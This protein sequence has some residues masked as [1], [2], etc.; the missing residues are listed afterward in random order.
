[1]SRSS[2]KLNRPLRSGTV[3][4]LAAFLMTVLVG[5][6]AFAID[7]GMIGLVREQ[8][9]IAADAGAMAGAN[10]LS[11]GTTTAQ[12][13]AQTFAQAN[14]V[15]G[16]NVS[17]VPSQDIQFGTWNK[18]AYTFTPLT[19]AAISGANAVKVTCTV[20]QARG[21]S[22]TL[23]FGPVLG[24][25][26]ADISMSAIATSSP[27]TCGAF[28]GINSVTISGGSYTDSYD[29]SAGAY[30]SGSAGKL[31]TVCS[32]GKISL[33]GGSTVVNGDAHPGPGSTVSASGGSSVTGSTTPLTSALN[34][35]AVNSGSAS[36]SNDNS[37]IPTSAL[38]KT[39]LDTSRN[40][41]LSGG[42]S[43]TLSP[44]T[45]YFNKFTLSGGSSVTITGK[46]II[47]CAGD[48]NISGGSLLNTTALPVN[49]QLYGMGSKVVLSG[50]SQWCGV[51][52]A[53]GCDVTRSGGSSDFFGMCVGKTLTLSGGGGLHYDTSLGALTGASNG[54]QLVQ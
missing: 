10:S 16:A 47:Y 11:S 17:I 51:V 30:S 4:V 52:Y 18:T 28:I 23:F 54:A 37:S 50:S 40:F 19:G 3:V 38:G 27:V 45:Y 53:P 20:S 6:A 36:S 26:W 35:P 14:V 9:Q 46:T 34:E 24:R 12:T 42:D 5:M 8:L 39:C 49:L 44:G 41:T 43:V 22:L 25:S 7:C 1:M 15:A 13:V 33:S 2:P 21:N 48:V 29:S 31:G 32:N